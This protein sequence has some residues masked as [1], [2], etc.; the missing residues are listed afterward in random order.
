MRRTAIFTFVGV[1]IALLPLSAAAGGGCHAGSAALSTVDARGN[2]SAVVPAEKCQFSPTTLWVDVGTR[3]TFINKDAVPHTVTG[4]LLAFGDSDALQKGDEVTYRFD[5]EG[6]FPYT[7]IIHPGMNGAIVVGDGMGEDAS[8]AGVTNVI[9]P[10]TAPST[11]NGTAANQDQGG[12]AV[13]AIG[14]GAGLA[15]GIALTVAGWQR[16][17][18]GLALETHF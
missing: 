5:N 3:V 1:A 9:G 16:H 2:G 11:E 4:P 6:V 10:P 13:P 14:L 17:R 15:T 18:R 7:C 8:S 12:L